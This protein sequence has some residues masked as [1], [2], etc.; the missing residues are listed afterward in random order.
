MEES[1]FLPSGSMLSEC[2][3]TKN[4]WARIKDPSFLD[5]RL[6]LAAQLIGTFSGARVGRPRSQS[7]VDVRLD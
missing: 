6:E 3:C 5:F 4:T 1:L 7:P 2:L